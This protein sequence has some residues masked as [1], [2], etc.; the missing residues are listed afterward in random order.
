[1]CHVSVF[2]SRIAC[3]RFPYCVRIYCDGNNNPAARIERKKG[4]SKNDGRVK[5]SNKGLK[6]L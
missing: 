2:F 3:F 6:L 5:A 4:H 1:M